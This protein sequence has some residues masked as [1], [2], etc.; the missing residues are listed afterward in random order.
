VMVP[1]R[2]LPSR[3]C[4]AELAEVGV[5][6]EELEEARRHRDRVVLAVHADD[7]RAPVAV[8]LAGVAVEVEAVGPAKPVIFTGDAHD[9]A[10]HCVPGL[11]PDR[12]LRRIEAPAQEAL[13]VVVL[14]ERYHGGGVAWVRLG[15]REAPRLR[16]QAEVVADGLPG[17]DLCLPP[18]LSSDGR[19]RRAL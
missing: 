18:R 10:A 13:G 3:C 19:R 7:Q 16:D 5:P 8:A 6:V 1:A 15:E 9:D 2:P 4:V 12:R 17:D 14:V 11:Y